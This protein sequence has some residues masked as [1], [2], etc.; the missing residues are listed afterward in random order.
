[1]KYILKIEIDGKLKTNLDARIMDEVLKL[2][3]GVFVS[4]YFDEKTTG[5]LSIEKK[6]NKDMGIVDVWSFGNDNR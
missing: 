4:Q 3:T 1:M 5:E 2:F 6:P